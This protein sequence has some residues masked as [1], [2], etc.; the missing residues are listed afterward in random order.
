MVHRGC[1]EM[2]A[3]VI[4]PSARSARTLYLTAVATKT[5]RLS[6][7]RLRRPSVLFVVFLMMSCVEV[8]GDGEVV[9][10]LLIDDCRESSGLAAVCDEEIQNLSVLPLIWERI[11]LRWSCLMSRA[12][13]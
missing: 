9:G 4:A 7:R 6:M 12:R 2:I 10:W 13:N 1:R 8:A 3:V 11:F 5:L